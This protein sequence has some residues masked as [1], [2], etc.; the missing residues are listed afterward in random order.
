MGSKSKLVYIGWHFV[1]VSQDFSHFEGMDR[2]INW[3]SDRD[4]IL[5]ELAILISII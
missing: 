4:Q 2:I 1:R 5:I 3:G